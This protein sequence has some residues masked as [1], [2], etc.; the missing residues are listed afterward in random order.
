MTGIAHQ[1]VGLYGVSR[2]YQLPID[3][4]IFKKSFHIY[5]SILSLFQSLFNEF[6]WLEIWFFRKPTNPT[7]TRFA[8]DH[9]P[10]KTFVVLEFITIQQQQKKRIN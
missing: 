5:F 8:L 6:Q 10:V 4:T 1:V 9:F 3:K 7:L 2:D